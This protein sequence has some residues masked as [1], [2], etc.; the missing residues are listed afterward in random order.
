MSKIYDQRT[1]ADE[2]LYATISMTGGLFTLSYRIVVRDDGTT[3][4]GNKS[5]YD[6]SVFNE[7]I[8]SGIPCLDLT[9]CEKLP[10]SDGVVEEYGPAQ[11]GTRPTLAEKVAQYAECGAIVTYL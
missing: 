11:F 5:G 9:T 7:A 6:R 2:P 10:F 1:S 8:G 4:T 3:I